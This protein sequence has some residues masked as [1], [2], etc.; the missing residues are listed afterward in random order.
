MALS[1]YTRVCGRRTPGNQLLAWTEAGNIASVTLTSGEI[2]A[3]TMESG[4][5][6]HEIQADRKTIRR[7]E[8]QTVTNAIAAVNHTIEAKFSPLS[9]TLKTMLDNL[10]DALPCGVVCIVADS[11]GKAWLVGY[12]QTE[13]D[14]HPLVTL[15]GTSDSGISS[16]ETDLGTATVVVSGMNGYADLPFDS[17]IA[18][19]IIG[20]TA[21]QITYVT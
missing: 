7:I 14:N 15:E 17:T 3:L 16:E 20:G 8:A 1:T 19:T 13:R 10:V 18:A 12:N 6:F 4:E 5:T 21:T 11:N 2:S 9:T